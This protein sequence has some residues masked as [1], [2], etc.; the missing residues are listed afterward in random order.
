LIDWD[1]TELFN[2]PLEDPYNEC[3][4]FL[5]VG[6]TSLFNNGSALVIYFVILVIYTVLAKIRC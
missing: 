3:L 4:D 2:L 5:E 6:G 1:L